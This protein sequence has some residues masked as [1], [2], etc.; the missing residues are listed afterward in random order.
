ME[1]IQGLKVA[2]GKNLGF[3]V[4]A[5]VLNKEE[6][7]RLLCNEGILLFR[8]KYGFIRLITNYDFRTDTFFYVQAPLGYA[9]SDTQ[10]YLHIGRHGFLTENKMSWSDIYYWGVEVKRIPR[11]WKWFLQNFKALWFMSNCPYCRGTTSSSHT[12]DCPLFQATHKLL[13][14]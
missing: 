5:N 10:T 11:F 6:M 13:T 9:F 12:Q 14:P 4:A 2:A 1:A 3:F 8:E 7:L